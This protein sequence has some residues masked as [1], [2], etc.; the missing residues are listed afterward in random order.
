VTGAPDG[1]VTP[2]DEYYDTYV[3]ERSSYGVQSEVVVERDAEVVDR[4]RH[5]RVL[6]V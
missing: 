4:L 6:N 5:G 2:L 3:N 1:C